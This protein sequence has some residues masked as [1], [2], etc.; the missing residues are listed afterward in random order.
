MSDTEQF[1]RGASRSVSALKGFAGFGKHPGWADHIDGLGD[2][3]GSLPEVRRILYLEGISELFPDWERLP[4]DSRIGFDHLFI[5]KRQD[6]VVSG[7]IVP[8]T[9][10]VKRGGFPFIVVAEVSGRSFPWVVRRLSRRVSDFAATCMGITDKYEVERAFKEEI[11]AFVALVAN[12]EEN[13]EALAPTPA[14]LAAFAEGVAP[15]RDM[16]GLARVLFEIDSGWSAFQSPTGSR[17]PKWQGKAARVRVP[18]GPSGEAGI[19]IWS[20]LLSHCVHDDVPRLFVVPRNRQ[21]LDIAA[22][23]LRPD[24]W[25]GLQANERGLAVESDVPH[26]IEESQSTHALEHFNGWMLMAEPA[27]GAVAA[28]GVFASET[29][30]AIPSEVEAKATPEPPSAPETPITPD[31]PAAPE[32][33]TPRETSAAPGIPTTPKN[34]AAP[35]IQSAAELLT[36]A[37]IP[38]AQEIS[39]ATDFSA[40]PETPVR[41]ENPATPEISATSEPPATPDIS[42]S[43]ATPARPENPA[44]PDILA[45]PGMT[46]NSEIGES[47]NRPLRDSIPPRR[48]RHPRV[49]IQR[50]ANLRRGIAAVAS[51]VMVLA[52]AAL[53][54]R[55][56]SSK[57]DAGDGLNP[58]VD[59]N[60]LKVTKLAEAAGQS[61]QRRDF[62]A[63]LTEYGKLLLLDPTDATATNRVALIKS[64]PTIE[65]PTPIEGFFGKPISIELRLQDFLERPVDLRV[66]LQGEATNLVWQD[67]RG[68]WFMASNGVKVPDSIRFRAN[69][70]YAD[71]VVS[72]PVRVKLDPLEEQLRLGEGA[73]L[74][75]R[76]SSA[77]ESYRAVTNLDPVNALAL[78]RL[79]LLGGAPNFDVPERLEVVAGN[80]LTYQL[81]FRPE[82][83]YPTESPWQWDVS[84][85][86]MPYGTFSWSNRS[87]QW[88]LESRTNRVGEGALAFRLVGPGGT[89]EWRRVHVSV[90]APVMPLIEG[91]PSAGLTLTASSGTSTSILL[92]AWSPASNHDRV[93][94]TLGEVSAGLRV[95]LQ[96]TNGTNWFL[97]IAAPS[98]AGAY[99]LALEGTSLEATRRLDFRV[100]A[101]SPKP[102]A[103]VAAPGLA[104][105]AVTDSV[106]LQTGEPAS[107]DAFLKDFVWISWKSG[108]TWPGKAGPG[109]WIGTHE[110]SRA[111]FLSVVK[112]L[113]EGSQGIGAK[114]AAGDAGEFPVTGVS[115][116]QALRYCELKTEGVRALL[117]GWR[118]DLPT[119]DE[120]FACTENGRI[121][122]D[123]PR[124]LEEPLPVR[125]GAADRRGLWHIMGNVSEI[126]AADASGDYLALG[127]PYGSRT[128][129]DRMSKANLTPIRRADPGL[130]FRLVL[131]SSVSTQQPNPSDRP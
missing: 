118:F 68:W 104:A 127:V 29:E 33:L 131:R 125:S 75:G 28:P 93:R 76:Y 54:I 46:E 89:S 16:T 17:P 22:G 30:T 95:E 74:A 109:F 110:V 53:G 15:G 6:S 20:D 66:D 119:A 34:P 111:E 88:T 21:W 61:F 50:R 69:N 108:A 83:S 86:E 92:R 130:G 18:I 65:P 1:R 78:R 24:H 73:W 39:D 4:P 35:Q 129:P 81:R 52:L 48:A 100:V 26:P 91:L 14:E 128:I 79:S 101:L 99:K 96:P 13:A 80:W 120:W 9:D 107:Q 19:L 64:P 49:A 113:P 98:V 72:V 38:A 25:F 84:T 121:P 55:W 7:R 43:P 126:S 112:S 8:S 37:G 122:K 27:G 63:A 114:N 36:T 10:R 115:P 11:P 117:H 71:T 103:V 12:P 23:E 40:S 97:R 124:G 106:P 57:P 82:G 123:V 105:P 87:G 62:R 44:T 31:P 116:A 47:S 85:N 41:P 5:W 102:V 90:R 42:A 70:G 51:S 56:W 77:L 32:I 45:K 58:L 2:M 3:R 60:R 94:L 67:E 59:E